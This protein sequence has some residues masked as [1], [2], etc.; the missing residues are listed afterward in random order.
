MTKQ[1]MQAMTSYMS[2]HMVDYA[3]ANIDFHP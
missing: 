3:I 2:G 1:R